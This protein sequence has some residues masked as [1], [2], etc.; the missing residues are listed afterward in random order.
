MTLSLVS[1]R[2]VRDRTALCLTPARTPPVSS[3][4]RGPWEGARLSPTCL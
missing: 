4:L 3:T 1:A 2:D